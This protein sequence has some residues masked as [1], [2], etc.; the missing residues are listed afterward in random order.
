M[1]PVQTLVPS[2]IHR[3]EFLKPLL[4][5]FV[6]EGIVADMGAPKTVCGEGRIP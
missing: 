2:G 3:N 4:Q 5:G 6:F 1:Q